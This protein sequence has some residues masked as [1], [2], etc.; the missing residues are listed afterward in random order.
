MKGRPEPDHAD[1]E[2]RVIRVT[3]WKNMAAKSI[4]RLRLL[5]SDFVLLLKEAPRKREKESAKL[6]KLATFGDE[7]TAVGCLRHDPNVLEV[8][9]VEGDYDGEEASPE[10]AVVLLEKHGVRAVVVTSWT[11][12]PENPRWRVFAPLSAP[13]QPSERSL[14]VAALNGVLGG[15]LERESFALSQ[16]YFIG[17]RP[18]RSLSTPVRHSWELIREQSPVS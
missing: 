9:G 16:S 6:V 17:G 14:Y 10:E 7:R 15:I 1:V 5:W 3:V 2:P 8:D 4:R 11:H 12:T 13:I 18:G